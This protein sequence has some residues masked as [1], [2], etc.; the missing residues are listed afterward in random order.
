MLILTIKTDNPNAE[1]ALLNG[2][3]ILAEEKWPAHRELSKDIHKKIEGLL[4]SHNKNWQ[5]IKGV[6]CFR[7]PGSFT[8]LRIGLA[9][10]NS[11]A[12]ELSIPIVGA[13]GSDW[14]KTC[15]ELL[16]QGKDQNF[17]VPEYGREARITQP[18]K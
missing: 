6:G 15:A 4:K 13:M 11:V 17:I 18:K 8:G 12:H 1:L 9:V 16:A 14:Q 2:S 10:G 5:D 7:G 3:G